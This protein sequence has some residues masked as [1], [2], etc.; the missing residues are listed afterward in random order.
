[1]ATLYKN[2][3]GGVVLKGPI[4]PMDN[5]PGGGTRSNPL[6]QVKDYLSKVQAHIPAEVVSIF[7]LGK[8]I[9]PDLAGTWAVVCWV[10][11]LVLRWFGT[12]GQG[13]ES[14]VIMTALAFPIWV[15]A[16]GGTILGFTFGNQISTLVML[17]FT[18]IAG[19]LYNNK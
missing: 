9:V 10:I 5:L 11:A 13:K 15:M 16:L 18:V 14:N 6:D 7:L 8:A 1:M 2:I 12:E 19:A 4:T 17:A 3:G